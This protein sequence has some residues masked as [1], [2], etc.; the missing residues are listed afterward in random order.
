MENKILISLT[1]EELTNI[2]K[3]AIKDLLPKSYGNNKGK[4]LTRYETAAI[5]RISTVT[6]NKWTKDGLI[7]AV[8]GN[9]R[10]RYYE[11]EIYNALKTYRKYG[12]TSLSS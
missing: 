3:A 11:S 6:L 8:R 7:P 1:P 10:V 4:L 2:I 5:L 12:R 9:S